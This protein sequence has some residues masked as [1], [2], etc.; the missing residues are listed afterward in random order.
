MSRHQPLLDE[1][2]LPALLTAFVDGEAISSGSGPV[3]PVEDPATEAIVV[4]YEETTAD[5]VASAVEGAHVAGQTWARRD[6]VDRGR[7]LVRVGLA[8]R[9][10]LDLLAQ[11]ESIDSGKPVSQS[12]ADMLACA[13][14]FEYYGGAVDKLSG[15]NLPQPAGTFTY[16]TRE[17]YG[18]VAHIT[19]WNSPLSQLVRGVAP[20]LAAG[21]SVVV[22]PS[23]LT[24]LTALV[25]AR[26][27]VEAGLPSGL[28]NIV[29]GEG[30]STGEALTTHPL[31]RHIT[32]TGSVAAGRRVGA[33]AA[34]RVV[35]VNLELGGKSPSIICADADLDKAANAGALAVIRNSGQS[36]FATTRLLVHRSVHDT[37]VTK[38]AEQIQGL[39][40][41]HGLDDPD[42]GPLISARQK[43]KVLGLVNQAVTDGAEAVVDGRPDEPGPGHFVRPTLFAGVTNDM[44]I[45]RAEVFGPVQSVIAFDTLEEA[46]RIAN[47]SEYGLS[48][49]VF[50]RDV[51]TAHRVAAELQAGQ[52]QVNRYS[53][54]GVEVPFGGYKNSGLG[55]EKGMEA[56]HHYTQLKSVIV[57]LD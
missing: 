52:V 5:G 50:T 19:P 12:R 22:K 21:N 46:V 6:P 41:G 33:V 10:Q 30:P 9:D 54:A 56:L 35:G 18:V 26:L 53:G 24:P 13:R 40:L 3:R 2:G 23:E 1:A 39:S 42:L 51:S 32:F 4:D 27:M 55:R 16:T 25:A 8:I 44:A 47:D 20:S 36:C 48:A 15:E 17:P 38:V 11:L 34:E 43:T 49:G 29:L 45:A 7:V 28:C 31:V 57:A 14:Y 37:F